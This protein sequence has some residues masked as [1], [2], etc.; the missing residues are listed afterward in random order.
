MKNI[1]L[2]FSTLGCTEYSVSE[3]VE[4]S[5][6][7]S[8]N[9]VEMRGLGGVMNVYEGEAFSHENTASTLKTF[10]DAGIS[11]P[12]LGTSIACHEVFGGKKKLD[13]C[14]KD[15][16]FAKKIGAKYIRVFGNKKTDTCSSPEVATVLL[17]LCALAAPYG[18]TVLLEVHGDYNST[19]M[20]SPITSALSDTEN[21]GLIWD[22][23]HTD[24]IY[25][26]G[27]EEFYLAMKPYIRHIHIKDRNRTTMKLT[28]VGEGDLP[29]KAIT[30]RLI[31]DGYDGFISLEWERKWHKELSPI[32]DALPDFVRIM[33]EADEGVDE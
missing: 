3:L 32:E 10:S 17:D 7:F 31:T 19:E 22:I 5:K 27:W 20:L 24:A 21:F 15:I 18:I 25:G 26:D 4:L 29:I 9:A 13:D 1:N 16:S 8:I 2:C 33:A 12:V 28:P 30:K 14:L 11:F 6:R 23:C